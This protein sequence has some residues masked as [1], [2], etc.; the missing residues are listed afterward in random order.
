MLQNDKS[1]SS[2]TAPSGTTGGSLS[3]LPS[4]TSPNSRPP[5]LSSTAAAAAKTNSFDQKDKSSQSGKVQAYLFIYLFN[6]GSYTLHG[7]Q[8]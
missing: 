6:L 4:A 8:K 2:S 7:N 5:T 1:P 3:K